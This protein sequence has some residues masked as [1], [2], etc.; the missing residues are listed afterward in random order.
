MSE[1]Q[2]KHK[3]QHDLLIDD[4]DGDGDYGVLGPLTPRE[5]APLISTHGRVGSNSSRPMSSLWQGPSAHLCPSWHLLS[6]IIIKAHLPS[7]MYSRQY[8][9][10]HRPTMLLLFHQLFHPFSFI[11]TPSMSRFNLLHSHLLS[12]THPCRFFFCSNDMILLSM[13]MGWYS[14]QL[15]G[16]HYTCE[17]ITWFRMPDSV[18]ICQS[19]N[20]L[21]VNLQFQFQGFQM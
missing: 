12:T 9:P 18:L 17:F 1:Q 11:Y 5:I 4:D 8:H 6:S 7:I 3:F 16:E 2:H 13:T 19:Q 20:L 10:G 21:I 15:Q 14:M